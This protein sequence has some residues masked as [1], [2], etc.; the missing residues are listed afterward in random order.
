[1]LRRYGRRSDV[2]LAHDAE[3]HRVADVLLRIGDLMVASG[4]A[5]VDV[6][7]SVMAAADALGVP[8]TEIDVTFNAITVTLFRVDGPPITQVR[9]VRQR[10]ANYSRLAA[11]HSLVVELV[12]DGLT[13]RDVVARLAEIESRPPTYP[14]WVTSCGWAMLAAAVTQLLG[15]NLLTA[16]VAFGSTALVDQLGRL[17]SRRGWPDF[18]LN[19]VGAFVATMVAVVLSA[20][21]TPVRPSL[22]VA[23][24][25][26]VLLSGVALVATVQDAITGFLVTAA[27][28]AV[29]VLLLTA[30]I[31]AGVAVGL[32]VAQQMG[33]VLSVR[34]PGASSLADLPSRTAAALVGAL[35]FAVAYQVPRRLLVPS[36]LA[37]A[38]GFVVWFTTLQAFQA[39][40]AAAAL[41]AV[42]AGLA[43]HVLGMRMNAPPLVVVVPSIVILLPGL[44][45]Y[46]GMLLIS[47]GAPTAGMLALL[48]A[49]T[50]G[51]A[52]AAGVLLGEVIGQPVRRELNRVERRFAGPRMVGPRRVRV[53]FRRAR[54]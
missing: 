45:I 5:T 19:L 27:G 35:A 12:D 8:R 4:A 43:S 38:L 7:A 46:R 21:D 14:R 23:G 13:R 41:A 15:G 39:P 26:I 18:F 11:V 47:D 33:I 30:G 40:A 6:E 53:R 37:G 34:P 1:L 17:L 2:P 29:E 48:Q 52:L 31:V 16:L 50:I 49:T 44:T 42:T 54:R 24:G 51:L 20:L 32:F 10:S 36:G 9:V 3:L 25:I 22:V 28:R